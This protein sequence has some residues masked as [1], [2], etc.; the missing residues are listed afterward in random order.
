M[1]HAVHRA[2]IYKS[3]EIGERTH[4]AVELLTRLERG[5][6]LL[7]LLLVLGFR[8]ETDGADGSLSA[9]FLAGFDNAEAD[10]LSLQ[11]VERLF[12]RNSALRGGYEHAYVLVEYNAS[13]AHYVLNRAGKNLAA[14]VCGDY[15]EPLLFCVK[16]LFGKLY[17]AFGVRKLDAYHLDLIADMEFLGKVDAAFGSDLVIRKNSRMLGS[18]IHF[19]LRRADRKNGTSNPFPCI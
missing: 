7:D 15:L 12:L 1:D 16:M 11:T 4:H 18:E 14:F 8:G 10:S 17:G 6:E 9:F 5:V 19:D 3:A 13:A 2:E